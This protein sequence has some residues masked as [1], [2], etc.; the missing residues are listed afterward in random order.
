MVDT[1]LTVPSEEA[2]KNSDPVLLEIH[3]VLNTGSVCAT[4]RGISPA[5]LPPHLTQDMGSKHLQHPS[6]PAD[7]VG[8]TCI[9]SQQ[10]THMMCCTSNTTQ[11][12]EVSWE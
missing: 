8:V 12:E 11:V 2:V 1:V 10:N 7:L 6:L 5:G 3:M 9:N 4:D